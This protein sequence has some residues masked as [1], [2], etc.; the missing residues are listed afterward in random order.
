MAF[1]Q[2][3][4]PS[5]HRFYI[6]PASVPPNLRCILPELCRRAPENN[7]IEAD[8]SPCTPPSG[9]IPHERLQHTTPIPGWTTYKWN[10][11][12]LVLRQRNGTRYSVLV[13]FLSRI[14]IA[15]ETRN[16]PIHDQA[17]MSPMRVYTVVVDSTGMFASIVASGVVWPETASRR[18]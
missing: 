13:A 14:I 6:N 2:E 8:T 15:M 9:T 10:R 5:P 1:S 17:N 16:P 18:P 3:A 12:T 4:I 7:W 11:S